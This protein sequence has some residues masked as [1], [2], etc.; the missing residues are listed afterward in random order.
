MNRY[1]LEL[2]ILFKSRTRKQIKTKYKISMLFLDENF[3]FFPM[4]KLVFAV[5]LIFCKRDNIIR[6]KSAVSADEATGKQ[7]VPFERT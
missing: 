4:V 7:S 2:P 5:S 6:G 1:Q 3:M